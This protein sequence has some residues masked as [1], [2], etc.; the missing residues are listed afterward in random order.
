MFF[1]KTNIIKEFERYFLSCFLLLLNSFFYSPLTY[2]LKRRT[3]DNKLIV[4][5]SRIGKFEH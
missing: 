3:A 1:Y 5:Q 2:L 4:K